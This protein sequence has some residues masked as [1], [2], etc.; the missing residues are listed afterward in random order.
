MTTQLRKK[1][2]ICKGSLSNQEASSTP[3]APA[4]HAC[5]AEGGGGRNVLEDEDG[6]VAGGAASLYTLLRNG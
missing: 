3:G 5:E 6:W 1:P 2:N 4:L